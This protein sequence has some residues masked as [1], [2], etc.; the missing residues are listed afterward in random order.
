M[1][2]HRCPSRRRPRCGVPPS[3]VVRK[4][5]CCSVGRWDET[6]FLQVDFTISIIRV[7]CMGIFHLF[8]WIF[9]LLV[10]LLNELYHRLH[11]HHSPPFGRYFSLN[12]FFSKLHQRV[13]NPTILWP[14]PIQGSALMLVPP[15]KR[16]VRSESLY[17]IRNFKAIIRLCFF[18]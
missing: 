4:R 10:F 2:K 12:R 3:C 8:S 16:Q 5:K 18:F 13:A 14:G 17:V 11:H 15:Q 1:S 9:F 7:L 6:P